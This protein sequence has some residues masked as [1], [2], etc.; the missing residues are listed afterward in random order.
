MMKMENISGGSPCAVCGKPAF[1]AKNMETGAPPCVP[2][3][4]QDRFEWRCPEHGGDLIGDMLKAAA[5]AER[6]ACAALVEEQGRLLVA[7]F[8]DSRHA[9][10]IGDLARAI[11][12]RK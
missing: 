8:A 3:P 7:I 12:A 5:N 9:P 4:S 1:L 2:G 11:R 10:L 6:E